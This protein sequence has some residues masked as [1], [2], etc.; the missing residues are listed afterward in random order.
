ML[1]IHNDEYSNLHDKVAINN[2]ECRRQQKF[3][4]RD[5]YNE[6]TGTH[7]LHVKEQGNAC[8]GFTTIV[9]IYTLHGG[10]EEP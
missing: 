1:I 2:Q 10:V 8:D 5:I 4:G 9:M 6:V 7:I 3:L